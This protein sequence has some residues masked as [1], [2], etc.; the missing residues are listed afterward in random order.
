M[1][2]FFNGLS[3][4]K[5]LLLILSLMLIG[6]GFIVLYVFK[7]IENTLF[8]ILLF[9]VLVTTSSL[10]S[11][12]M[13]RHYQKKL[14]KKKRGKM[15]YTTNGLSLVGN[16]KE[17]VVNYGK[18]QFYFEKNVIYNLS[19]ITNPE[20]FFSD[21]QEEIKL[22]IDEKKYQKSVQFF[23]FDS[24]RKDLYRKISILNYQAKRFYVGSFIY[25]EKTQL[26]YQTDAV[27]PDK[28]FEPLIARMLELLNLLEKMD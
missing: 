2:K 16:T 4:K 18:V 3:N 13:N 25:D 1:G 9:I 19:I 6:A 8:I 24:K 12:L 5:I 27:K 15:Y 28:E 22:K 20:L 17:Y 10:S 21:N 23:V 26:F 14:D 11:L 7:L